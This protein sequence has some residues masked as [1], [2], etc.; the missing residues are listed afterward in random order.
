MQLARVIGT[1]VV[2]P[3]DFSPL[4]LRTPVHLRGSFSKPVITVDAGK[5]GARVGASALLALVNPFAA[6]LPFIDTGKSDDAKRGAQACRSL[7]KRM[8]ASASLPAPVQ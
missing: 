6:I 8:E 1:V 7:S 2:T 3:K 4:A 5:L